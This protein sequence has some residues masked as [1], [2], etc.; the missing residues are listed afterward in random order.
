M[1]LGQG[2]RG[3]GLE[4]QMARVFFRDVFITSRI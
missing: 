3:N 2:F 4:E 1:Q